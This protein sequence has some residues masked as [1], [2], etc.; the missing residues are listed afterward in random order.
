MARS[1][2]AFESV[3]AAE[4][5]LNMSWMREWTYDQTGLEALQR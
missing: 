4:C 1:D 5:E 3:S 2:L